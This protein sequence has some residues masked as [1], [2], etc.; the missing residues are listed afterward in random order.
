MFL[1]CYE[2][3]VEDQSQDHADGYKVKQNKLKCNIK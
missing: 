3:K 1:I 2:S